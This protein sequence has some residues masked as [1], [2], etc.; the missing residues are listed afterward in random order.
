MGG[1]SRSSSKR[2][3]QQLKSIKQ[4]TLLPPHRMLDP[5]IEQY[6]YEL[7]LKSS[8]R[9]FLGTKGN[10][11]WVNSLNIGNVM[12]LTPMI[13]EELNIHVDNSHELSRD[14]LLEKIILLCVSYFCIGT[15]L[16]FLSQKESSQN[17]P[18]TESEKWHAKAL[19]CSATFLPS[20]CPLVSHIIHSYQK[21]HSL[22]NQTIVCLFDVID[23]FAAR[24]GGAH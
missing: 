16:R 19:H 2:S 9:R 12:H 1:M 5:D 23:I 15:E 18:K 3:T 4:Q 8:V 13:L 6:E 11:D 14:A 17:Y 24:G 10:D 22:S 21:H 20:E 7:S